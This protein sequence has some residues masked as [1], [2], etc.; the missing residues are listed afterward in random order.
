MPV[1]AGSPLP[2]RRDSIPCSDRVVGYLALAAALVSCLWVAF[3]AL[4]AP[5]SSARREVLILASYHAGFMWDDGI[6]RAVTDVLKPAEDPLEL[7]FEYMDTKRINDAT[8][9]RMLHDLYRYKY[10]DTQFAVIIASDN[11]AFDFLREYRDELFPDV[12]VVF[13]GVNFF[14][15]EMLAGQHSFT[16]AA[17]T[18]DAV[19]TLDII[20]K[21]H[22]TMKTLFVLNDPDL[23]GQAWADD[24]RRQIAG[25]YPRLRIDYAEPMTEAQAIERVRALPTD[26]V[27]LLGVF[28]RDA[29]GQYVK[30][31]DF[32]RRLTAASP[33]PVY[34]LLDLYIGYGI[35]GGHIIDGYHQGEL[36]ARLARRVLD[37][38]VVDRIPV[39]KQGVTRP[40]FDYVQLRRFDIPKSTL[41]EGSVILNQPYSFYEEHKSKI[42]V[43][44]AFA[45]AAT[46]FIFLLSGALV[47]RRKAEIR[48]RDSQQRL[49]LTLDA[50]NEGVWDWRVPTGETVFSPRYYTMLDYEPYEF[51]QNRAAWI[52][53]LHPDDVERAE[54]RVRQHFEHGETYAVELRMR[55]KSGGWRWILARGL[56]VE[57][58]AAGHPLRMVGTHTDITERKQ[59][60][61]ALKTSE[62][63]YRALIESMGEGLIAIDREARLTYANPQFQL[64]TGF[65]NE[66]LRDAALET[67][68]SDDGKAVF[69]VQFER[70][71][72]GIAER[73]EL[74]WLKKDG[75]VILTLVSPKPLH[76]SEGHFAGSFAAITDITESK[77]AERELIA[78]RDH[79]EELVRERTADLARAKDAAEAANRAKSL[80]LANMSHELRTPLNA[81]LGFS[82]LMR[83]DASITDNHLRQSLDIINRSGEHLLALINDILDMAKIE[84]GRL[85]ARIKPLNLGTLA[86]DVVELMRGRATEKG[87]RL[88]LEQSSALPRLVRG[89]ETKLRQALVNLVG[90]AIKFTE[91]GEVILRLGATP[92]SCG[93][94]LSIEVEDSG[95][96]IA[97]AD[98]LRIFDPFAQVEKTGAQ[99][100]TGLGLAI[101]R[102]FVELMGGRIGVTSQ[103]GRGSCFQIELP[104]EPIAESEMPASTFD[105]GDVS[106]LEPGQ[107]DYRV[108]VVEDQPENAQLL[109][110]LLSE[111]GFQVRTAENGVQGV[112]LFQ[113][114]RP[115]FIWMDR[116][117]PEMDGLEATRRIRNLEGG[118]E[119]KIVALTASVFV[120]Q[121]Q[122]MLAAGMNDVV[123]KPFQPAAIFDCLARHLGARY[124][125]QKRATPSAVTRTTVDQADLAALPEALR[126]DLADALVTLNTER[127]DALIGRVAERDA[128][129]GQLLRRYTD[130]YDYDPIIKTLALNEKTH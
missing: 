4:A 78:Y 126:Q 69:R 114:W 110:R 93:L 51:P 124:L 65:S 27:V 104:V 68:L 15:D 130:N 86:H 90:N 24:I 99:K 13:C 28:L 106:T 89:D 123:H 111:A 84:A 91:Q 129:L 35:V 37:G 121:H 94:R 80:F 31:P 109:S 125:Y 17:E 117:L 38:E 75:G 6:K 102:Q 5:A 67:L 103:L 77:R 30:A 45:T 12:P 32:A 43:A 64:M 47:A 48:L 87:L 25:R 55:S 10:R 56:V 40:M 3:P 23:T 96:G 108:L 42:F 21:A 59:A 116:R 101:T 9:A 100:G 92:E 62:E 76:D 2:L 81:I 19:A 83:R 63:R 26:T 34:G 33:V 113:R 128:A 73:Y 29:Q 46:A 8:Y 119:V 41:P 118:R 105:P 44:A 82:A 60:E 115:H 120:E 74:E 36:V 72:Q 79:L 85:Q 11:F 1:L 18:F 54:R 107:P 127:I 95:I 20:V 16:G 53:L 39:I 71:K 70:R 49:T 66:E 50:V 112:E 58:D 122:E 57:R 97:V 88:R 22:P 98:Q 61:I 14:R 52:G 7:H